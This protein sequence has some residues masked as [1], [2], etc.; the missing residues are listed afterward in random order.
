LSLEITNNLYPELS[1]VVSASRK[2]HGLK[3]KAIIVT[4]HSNS[5][6]TVLKVNLNS[7]VSRIFEREFSVPL[8]T[9]RSQLA[10]TA[11]SN[12]NYAVS[13]VEKILIYMTYNDS[14]L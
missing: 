6:C 13:L 1:Y 12:Q 10:V 8:N 11:V 2:N 7:G 4:G 3:H 14:A 9:K 5:F